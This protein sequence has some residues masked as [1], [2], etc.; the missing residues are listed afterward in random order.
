MD[1]FNENHKNDWI[2][3]FKK[4]QKYILVEL[5]DENICENVIAFIKKFLF[6]PVLHDG[7]MEVCN[8]LLFMLT[9]F[10]FVFTDF[11]SKSCC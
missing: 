6:D 3:V 9:P 4:L 1:Q 2:T 7:M 5:C 8:S 10:L 11:V